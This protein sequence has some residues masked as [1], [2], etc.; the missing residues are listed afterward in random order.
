MLL[1][2]QLLAIVILLAYGVVLLKRAILEIR[3]ASYRFGILIQM[4]TSIE[5]AKVKSE[6]TKTIHSA[7]SLAEMDPE[8]RSE[9]LYQMDED[10]RKEALEGLQQLGM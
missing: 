2:L 9:T 10:E 6:G 7:K 1:H 5:A 3:S 8:T 4:V